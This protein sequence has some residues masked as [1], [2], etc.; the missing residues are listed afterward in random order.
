MKKILR[1]DILTSIIIIVVAAVV[2]GGWIGLS[3]SDFKFNNEDNAVVAIV[4]DVKI[5]KGEYDKVY[6]QIIVRA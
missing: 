3:R 1:K 2:A 5:Q 4:N 6:S